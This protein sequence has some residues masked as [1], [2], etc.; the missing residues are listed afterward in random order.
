MIKKHGCC[1]YLSSVFRCCVTDKHRTGE[2]WMRFSLEPFKSVPVKTVHQLGALAF[3][4]HFN[5]KFAALHQV[6]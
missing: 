6:H 2:L 4:Q 5:S 3:N 1:L